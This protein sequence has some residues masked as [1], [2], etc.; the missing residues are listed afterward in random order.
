MVYRIRCLFATDKWCK[1]RLTKPSV[2]DAVHHA[3]T[4]L[5]VLGSPSPLP[6]LSIRHVGI[7]VF[8]KGIGLVVSQLSPCLLGRSIATGLVNQGS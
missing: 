3:D 8:N 6:R 2:A 5:S 1:A 4:L 7:F